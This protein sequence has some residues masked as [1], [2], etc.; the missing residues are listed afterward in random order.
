MCWFKTLFYVVQWTFMLLFEVTS[1]TQ[2]AVF[3]RNWFD[4]G[5]V[6]NVH[7]HICRFL[8][9]RNCMKFPA[10]VSG[11]QKLRGPSRP[12]P[13]LYTKVSSKVATVMILLYPI[14][15]TWTCFYG[16]LIASFGQTHFV[17]LWRKL[18]CVN[19]MQWRI[20]QK[21]RGQLQRWAW[22]AII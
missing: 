9:V 10:L 13:F 20:S 4:H 21:R 17:R 14:R 22:K 18:E 12:S 11:I 3:L 6:Q 1:P 5:L 15:E 19:L 16:G 7:T 8:R 2:V